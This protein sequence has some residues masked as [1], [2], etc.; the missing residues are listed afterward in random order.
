MAIEWLKHVLNWIKPSP[1]Y[2]LPVSLAT[3]FYIF[4]PQK[5]YR[6]FDFPFFFYYGPW[7]KAIFIISCAFNI[8][9]FA[10]WSSKGVKWA[11]N[12]IR[13]RWISI[14]ALKYLSSEE[15]SFLSDYIIRQ[16]KSQKIKIG[17]GIAASLENE[18]IIYQA[19][20]AG[21]LR[22]GF[23]YNLAPWIWRRLKDQPEILEPELS[24]AKK[25]LM[26]YEP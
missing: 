26:R 25:T 14:R 23:D 21:N 15:K 7:I 20:P 24:E 10:Y 3:G 22:S 1:K 2:F 6:F 12:E 5:V 9:S 11:C 4:A 8:T 19:S 13:F 17:A 16:S 18:F